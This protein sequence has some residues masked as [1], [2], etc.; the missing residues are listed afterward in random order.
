[1]PRLYLDKIIPNIYHE[2][3]YLFVR[4]TDKNKAYHFIVD[5]AAR[6]PTHEKDTWSA[7][8]N[9]LDL[10][11]MSTLVRVTYYS[12]SETCDESETPD[13]VK[14][15]PKFN[16]IHVGKD[17]QL[18][19]NI[20]AINDYLNIAAE[21]RTDKFKPAVALNEN[22]ATEKK[23]LRKFVVAIQRRY[24]L[25]YP[26]YNIYDYANTSPLDSSII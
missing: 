10:S 12:H 18:E 3:L 19:Q 15:N 21:S 16:L 17:K 25:R 7:V 13:S 2:V 4:N 6:D 5:R 1:M 26:K 14:F 8:S 22:V 9:F 23:S 24:A 11:A 20:K